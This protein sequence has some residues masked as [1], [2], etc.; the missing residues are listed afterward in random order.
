MTDKELNAYCEAW[1]NW[2][3]TR[4]FYLQ[5]GA[6]NILARMLPSKTGAPPN[7][8]N[9]PDMQFFNMAIHAMA[10]MPK[11]AN[12]FACFKIT[13]IEQP[14]SIKR[15]AANLEIDRS[16]FYRRANAFAKKAY[17]MRGSL[18]AAH[19]AMAECDLVD[20]D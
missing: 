18:K 2:C 5:P 16:T 15:A 8:R 3:Y 6:Q 13:Y 10:D 20:A 19:H 7:A 17:S 1:V 12:G 9:D 4:R 14:D 11:H